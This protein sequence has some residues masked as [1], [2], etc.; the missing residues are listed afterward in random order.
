MNAARI[1]EAVDRGDVR[2][3]ER[4]EQFRLAMK[5]RQPV[6]VQHERLGEDLQRDIAAQ[7][8]VAR[9]IHLPHSAGPK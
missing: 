6:G 4:G 8:R 3:V 1:L 2:M 7:L 5:A 9:V